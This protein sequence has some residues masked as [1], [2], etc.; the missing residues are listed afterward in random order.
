[1]VFQPSLQPYWISEFRYDP[2]QE[3]A[4][5]KMPLLILQ[6]TTDIQASVRDAEL[7]AKANPEAKLVVIEGMNHVLKSVLPDRR[8][9]LAS[10]A[11][12]RCRWCRDW[13]TRSRL[14]SAG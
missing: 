6:G 2:A 14:W 5:L 1:M 11:I 9:Q 8:A 10:M 7:L 12:R 4:S 3:I 13:W